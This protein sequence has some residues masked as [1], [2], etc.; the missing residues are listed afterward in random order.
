MKP[1][2]RYSYI[3]PLGEPCDNPAEDVECRDYR[4]MFDA[5]EYGFGLARDTGRDVRFSVYNHPL[6]R[7]E[8]L[9]TLRPDGTMLTWRGDVRKFS[10]CR[11]RYWLKEGGRR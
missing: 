4:D 1:L 3:W 11:D 6:R 8:H 9:G 10:G 7:W 5:L 2:E